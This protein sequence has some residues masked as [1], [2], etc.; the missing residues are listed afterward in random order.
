MDGI[1]LGVIFLGA[2]DGAMR[3]CDSPILESQAQI[4]YE[5]ALAGRKVFRG[6]MFRLMCG[7]L[8]LRP[9]VHFFLGRVRMEGQNGSQSYK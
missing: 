2:P 8:K 7:C 3:V 1:N 4:L 9:K 6:E 5:R